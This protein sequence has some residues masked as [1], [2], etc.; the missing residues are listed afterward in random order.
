MKLSTMTLWSHDAFDV[1]ASHVVELG[2][3]DTPRGADV[4][5]EGE[6]GEAERDAALR[7]RAA[8]PMTWR[9]EARWSTADEARE[10]ALSRL[11][12]MVRGLRGEARYEGEAEMIDG[13]LRVDE[14]ALTVTW[15]VGEPGDESVAW[16]RA[17]RV[18]ED[19]TPRRVRPARD[20]RR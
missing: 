20:N 1:S 14:D 8:V 15:V 16:R 7:E 3:Y 4:D 6:M 10:D 19:A 9:P 2:I 12:A 13:C 17:W 5:P 11:R 18:V